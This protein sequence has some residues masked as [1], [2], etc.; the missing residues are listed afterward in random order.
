M[1]GRR[2]LR[3]SSYDSGRGIFCGCRENYFDIIPITYMDETG[4]YIKATRN[5]RGI[6]AGR[7]FK[8]GETIYEVL[9]EFVPVE[10]TDKNDGVDLTDNCFRF[11]M[12]YNQ[13][14]FK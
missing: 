9:G 1:T 12:I 4:V 6:F 10:V 2:N 3:M 7:D 11:D 5:G 14:I 8:T 13:D